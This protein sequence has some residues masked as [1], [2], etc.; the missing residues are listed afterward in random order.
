M[1]VCLCDVGGGGC[2]VC[3]RGVCECVCVGGW[4]CVCG[5][6]GGGCV[7]GVVCVCGMCGMCVW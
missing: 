3:V 1:C 5:V 7:V 4:M 6:G 2:V